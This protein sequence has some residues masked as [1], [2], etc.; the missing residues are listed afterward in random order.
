M[1]EQQQGQ[2]V[3]GL[4]E[5]Y[6]RMLEAQLWQGPTLSEATGHPLTHDILSALGLLEKKDDGS[7][8]TI[9]FEEDC[10]K[11]QSRMIAD[12][13]VMTK[14]RGSLSS[15]SDRSHRAQSSSH[16][17][18]VL[19]KPPLFKE[20][21]NFGSSSP[22]S[23]KTQSPPPKKRKT[24]PPA[25]QSPL[26]QNAP[27]TN[28]DPQLYQPDWALASQTLSDP[29]AILKANYMMKQPFQQQNPY[30]MHDF[31]QDALID[32]PMTSE[33][34]FGEVPYSQLTSNGFG[35]LQDFGY[36]PYDAM[37]EVDFKNFIATA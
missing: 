32:S 19:S 27:M 7:D 16:S 15:D 11:L 2:L 30:D 25:V 23:P 12:G 28:N 35:S 34:D 22:S 1:L 17:T 20:S 37:M 21:F 13:A 33:F 5:M 31:T 18:P 29:E 3:Q 6:H 14:R 4:Q 8:E 36:A 10:D 24:Y 9:P 26:H